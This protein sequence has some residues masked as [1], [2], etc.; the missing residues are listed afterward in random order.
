MRSVGSL[1]LVALAWLAGAHVAVAPPAAVDD[2]ARFVANVDEARAHLRISQELYAAGKTAKAALHSSHPVQELGSRIF[3][4]IKKADPGLGE[5]VR[6][7]LKKPRQAADG[8]TPP[9][10][11]AALI[12]E[13]EAA[14]DEAVGRVVPKDTLASA[15][16]QAKVIGRLLD[17]LVEEYEEAW[18]AGRIA[19]DVE[20]HDA[21]GFFRQIKA[22]AAKLPPDVAK[23]VSADVDAL[24]RA[25]P[26]V[27]PPA[28][29]LPLDRVKAL[30]AKIATALRSA[31]AT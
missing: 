8:K 5:R 13:I 22:R 3:G 11:Y 31:I 2:Q 25:F 16:F 12:N 20:Y 9:A 19:Q 18:K 26:G 1:L 21:W 4:P 27:T 29:P 24:G 6:A 14:L 23:A 15:A 7:L 17:A 10:Q 30:A 28:R